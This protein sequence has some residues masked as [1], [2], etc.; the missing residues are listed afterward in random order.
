M[1]KDVV[2][3]SVGLKKDRQEQLEDSRKLQ[4]RAGADASHWRRERGEEGRR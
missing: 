1:E 2:G 4:H 3:W